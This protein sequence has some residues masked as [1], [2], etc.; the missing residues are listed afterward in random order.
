MPTGTHNFFQSNE[1]AEKSAWEQ[2]VDQLKKVAKDFT[3]LF[4][5]LSDLKNIAAKNP[6]LKAEYDALMSKGSLVRSQVENVTRL[7]DK[8]VGSAT[9]ILGKESTVRLYG[10]MGE[11]GFLP[12]V[13][14][15]MIIGAIAVVGAW[16]AQAM[17]LR[18][19]LQKAQLD[20]AVK[21]GATAEQ[22]TQIS[23][24]QSLSNQSKSFEGSVGE[25]VGQ[26]IKF[27]AVGLVIYFV[28]P[29]LWE[30]FTDGR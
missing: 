17:I 29:K 21:A 15:A 1:E 5:Q 24:Q 10:M 13:P 4:S 12:L 16:N 9:S 11:M 3:A 2:K 30:A 23:Q 27:A 22:I 6:V 19:K 18:T 7:I 8:A 20:E 25:A 28:V 14:I 26:V